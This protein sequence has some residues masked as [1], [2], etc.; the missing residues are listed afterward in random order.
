MPAAERDGRLVAA[1]SKLAACGPHYL[2]DT[3]AGLVPVIDAISE[4]IA[5]GETPAPAQF[6]EPITVEDGINL[7]SLG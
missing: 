6:A 1:Y 7:P 5:R 3:V 2:I 4:R